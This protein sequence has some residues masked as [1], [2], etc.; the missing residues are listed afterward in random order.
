[1]RVANVAGRCNIVL[2]GLAYDVE[3]ASGGRF[4][5]DPQ[6]AFE[7]WDELNGW[8]SGVEWA[9]APPIEPRALELGDLGAPA[10]RPRQ[11][12]AIGL[13]Y[14]Q[15]AAEANLPLPDYPV[16]FTKFPSCIAGPFSELPLPSG[17]V[18]W[19][20]EMV[21]VM[22]REARQISE[23]RAWDHVAGIAVG[24]DISERV[25]QGR[26]P[27]PQFSM[28]KSFPYFGPF[29]PD[30][31]TIDEVPDPDDVELRC[32]VNGE[33]VQHASTSDLIFSV[34]E[35]IAYLSS[36]A[37]LYPGDVIFTGT[38]S[39]VGAARKP[40]WFLRAGDVVASELVGISRIEQR[41]TASDRTDHQDA[42][43]LIS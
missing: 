22:G 39:G 18:D 7:R 11:V 37:T 3:R 29:G 36:I 6:A 23:G 13:N 24:Q 33:L 1:M 9:S 43:A 20:V 32:T 35:I 25:V 42:S 26:P 14:R 30:I 27:Q 34:P 21:A 8:A 41:C 2:D 12:F 40:A 17:N 10:P 4:G 19:E 38:P 15:H 16:V 5:A 28:G 31:V